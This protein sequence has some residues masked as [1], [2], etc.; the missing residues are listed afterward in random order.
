MYDACSRC[1]A[2]ASSNAMSTPPVRAQCVEV[3]LEQLALVLAALL[4]V[5]GHREEVADVAQVR[6]HARQAPVE[7]ADA[8]AVEE[9]V[10][11]VR[12]AVDVASTGRRATSRRTSAWCST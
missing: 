10:A 9:D 12:V 3:A 8:V 6:A 4:D 11:D 1:A 7:E 2:H 5:D